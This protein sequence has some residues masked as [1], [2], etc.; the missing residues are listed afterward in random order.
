MRGD[1]ECSSVRN[2]LYHRG[3]ERGYGARCV[4]RAA[5]ASERRRATGRPGRNMNRLLAGL[6]LSVCRA[7][8]CDSDCKRGVRRDRSGLVI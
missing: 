1:G 3:D 7:H 8:C 2:G 6:S 5:H 4:P